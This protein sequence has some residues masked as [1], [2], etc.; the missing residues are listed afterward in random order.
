MKDMCGLFS[1]FGLSTPPDDSEFNTP[2]EAQTC[3][4]YDT[5]EIIPPEDEKR[6]E[7]DCYAEENMTVVDDTSVIFEFFDLQGA[8][9]E[10]SLQNPQPETQLTRT[11]S[12][13]TIRSKSPEDITSDLCKGDRKCSHPSTRTIVRSSLSPRASEH[14]QINYIEPSPTVSS[15]PSPMANETIQLGRNRKRLLEDI[16]GLS[17]FE[18]GIGSNTK[19]KRI[20]LTR[21]QRDGARRCS[22]SKP[23]KTCHVLFTKAYTTKTL[24]WTACVS[25]HLPDINLFTLGIT[26]SDDLDS[27]AHGTQSLP[28][29]DLATT[30]PLYG[31]LF[32]S[33]YYSNILDLDRLY[34][35]VLCHTYGDRAAEVHPFILE[36]RNPLY[37]LIQINVIL[38]GS[39]VIGHELVG[40]IKYLQKLRAICAVLA[41]ECL[42]KALDRTTLAASSP[43]RQIAII[44]QASLLLDQ[45]L[46]MEGD[47]P[48]AMICFPQDKTYKDM[49]QHLIQYITYYLRRLL[50]GIF[51][52]ESPIFGCIRNA[53]RGDRLSGAFWDMLSDLVPSVPLRRP[54]Q[55]HRYADVS[56]NTCDVESGRALHELFSSQ[57]SITC[58]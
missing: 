33:G 18:L 44:I 8:T 22:E 48:A 24:E 16:P 11:T 47:L 58:N 26:L 1:T 14:I 53:K 42:G 35:K 7:K 55:L 10:Y 51:R 3:T 19:T 28:K 12:P 49:H 56:W 34:V 15:T 27:A 9:L 31:L 43:L 37:M 17:C 54:P 41:F 13:A 45:V 29:L 40:C 4:H 38:L 2:Q 5:T 57:C 21:E 6:R 23:C 25:S 30:A 50:S 20:R 32:E 39:P 46:E 52:E 36:D